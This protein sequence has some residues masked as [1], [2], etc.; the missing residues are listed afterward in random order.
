MTQKKNK[1]KSSGNDESEYYMQTNSVSDDSAKK[2]AKTFFNLIDKALFWL[3]FAPLIDGLFISWLANN[4]LS[5]PIKAVI[6]GTTALSGGGCIGAVIINRES[7]Q[8][9]FI[10]ICLV[11]V[12]IF[13]SSITIGLFKPIF[14]HVA[15]ENFA[16]LTSAFLITLGIKI[17]GSQKLDKL[18]GI[19]PGSAIRVVMLAFFLNAITIRPVFG[20]C[21]DR[22]LIMNISV[23]VLSGFLFTCVG[24]LFSALTTRCHNF[25][26][27]WLKKGQAGSLILMGLKIIFPVIPTWLVLIPLACGFVIGFIKISSEINL[28]PTWNPWTLMKDQRH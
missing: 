12:I 3:A 17:S 9:K 8:R 22:I 23:A 24:L 21:T 6:F 2:N 18:W 1:T 26:Y 5:C 25:D 19:D 13:F 7:T 20:I 16:L 28:N 11:Y 27:S 14:V 10:S 15:P 4:L